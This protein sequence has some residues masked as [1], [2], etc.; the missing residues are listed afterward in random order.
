MKYLIVCAGEPPSKAL[1]EREMKDTAQLISCDGAADV[2]ERYGFVPNLMVGDFDSL[3]LERSVLLQK[4]WGAERI[5]LNPD[6]DKPDSQVALELAVAAGA[7]KIVILG[8]LG[9]RFDHALGNVLMMIP[10]Q[11][12]GVEMVMYDEQNEVRVCCGLLVLKGQVGD[13]LSLIPLGVNCMIR[14]TDGLHYPLYDHEFDLGDNLGIS[15]RFVAEEAL[16]EVAHG[17]FCVI[18]SKD[19]EGEQAGT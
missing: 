7:S 13:T 5:E 15:N 18:R 1:L 8:A 6:K 12:Q 10:P 3:G 9:R 2:L 11:R 19:L 4:K 16:V 17:W 14:C